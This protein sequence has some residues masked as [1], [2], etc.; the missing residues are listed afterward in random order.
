MPAIHLL[1]K[2]KVQGVYYRAS[3]KEKAKSLGITGWVKNTPE[4]FVE[5]MA[6]GRQ[7]VLEQMVT[8][9]NVGPSAAI[10]LEVIVTKMG[11]QNF[12]AFLIKND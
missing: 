6:N 4:G 7:E 1:I 5:I 10:V 8:W 12:N 2:G 9:C 11:E 3:A